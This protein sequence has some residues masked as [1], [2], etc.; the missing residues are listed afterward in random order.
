ME[1]VEAVI[2]LEP[3][4]EYEMVRMLATFLRKWRVNPSEIQFEENNYT[5][6]SFLDEKFQILQANGEP[7]GYSNFFENS[8][9]DAYSVVSSIR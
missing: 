1:F 3:L 4:E 7:E 2:V 5:N 8:D 9:A 6:V